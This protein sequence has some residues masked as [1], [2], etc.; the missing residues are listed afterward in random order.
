MTGRYR[1]AHMPK[2][3]ELSLR[4][5]FLKWQCRVRQIV[6]RE[7]Q[8]RPDSS[9]APEVKF[10]VHAETVFRCVTVLCR[11]AEHSINPELHH[12]VKST[13]ELAARRDKA[14]GFLAE[15]YYQ[16]PGLFADVLTST[17]EADSERF[18]FLIAQKS[19]ILEFGAYNHAYKLKCEVVSYE[20]FEHYWQATYWHNVLFNPYLQPDIK[21]VGFV[22]DWE[23]SVAIR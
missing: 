1:S 12:M 11:K 6:M 19:C 21:V 17:F 14:V 16:Q 2:P 4:D 15:R 5:E 13:Q 10:P 7:N 23:E 20:Q 22:P 8:G 3:H 9:V 18:R